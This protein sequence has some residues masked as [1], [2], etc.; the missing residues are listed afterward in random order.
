VFQIIAWLPA[1][2]IIFVGAIYLQIAQNMC[3]PGGKEK[4]SKTRCRAYIITLQNN[5][6]SCLI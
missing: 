1:W 2:V 6:E 4:E 3:M 5:K